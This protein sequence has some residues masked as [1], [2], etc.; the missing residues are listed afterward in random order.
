MTPWSPNL[1]PTGKPLDLAFNT[2]RYQPVP[3][4]P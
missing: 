4:I 3:D 2:V 1:L